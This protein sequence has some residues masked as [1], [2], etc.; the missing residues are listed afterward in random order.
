MYCVIRP[1]TIGGKK[2]SDP[3]L[4]TS[5]LLI[6]GV[7]DNL[8]RPNAVFRFP[9]QGGTGGIWKKVAQKLLPKEN[10]EYN[11]FLTDIDIN[12]QIC[13]FKDGSKIKYKKLLST[14]PLDITLTMLGK[15][16]L[17]KRLTYSSSHIIGL[18]LRGQNPHDTKV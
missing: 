3:T 7:F 2:H 17:A 13:T 1:K 11:K 18:G 14:I 8:Y 9:Q 16:E 10:Q 15:P 12:G 5:S 4:L 6:F